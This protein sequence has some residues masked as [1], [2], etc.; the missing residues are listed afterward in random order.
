MPEIK[1]NIPEDWY[2]LVQQ[3][4][5]VLHRWRVISSPT[6]EETAKLALEKIVTEVLSQI[7]RERRG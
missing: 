1:L 3:T 5:R 4:G 7:G 6:P 2:A